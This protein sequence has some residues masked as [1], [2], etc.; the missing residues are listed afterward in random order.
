[1]PVIHINHRAELTKGQKRK[2]SKGITDVFVK[3]IKKEPHLVEIFWHDIEDHNF[4]KG[5][6]LLEDII[7]KRKK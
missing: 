2:L 4:A 1:M 7:K 6:M 3:M 5:G